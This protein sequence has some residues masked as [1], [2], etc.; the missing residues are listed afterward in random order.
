ME[1][2]S[3]GPLSE[4]L[5]AN[6]L[7]VAAL[8]SMYNLPSSSFSPPFSALSPVSPLSPFFASSPVLV[9]HLLNRC[10]DIAAGMEFLASKSIV[11]RDLGARNILVTESD[12]KLVV[13]VRVVYCRSL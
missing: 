10:V 9:V 4:F 2:L 6:D 1:Y 8:V 5:R 3:K 11:H 12:G 7:E 13:K